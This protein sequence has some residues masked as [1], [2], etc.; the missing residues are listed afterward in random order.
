[1][2][3]T[4]PV[5][6]MSIETRDAATQVA[7]EGETYYFCSKHCGDEFKQAPQQYTRGKAKSQGCCSGH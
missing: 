7:H 5:C 6:G 2:K 1:M 4:D 3:V